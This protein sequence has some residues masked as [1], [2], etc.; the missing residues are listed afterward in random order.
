ME[1]ENNTNDSLLSLI[2]NII[3]PSAILIGSKKFIMI[4]PIYSLALALSFPFCYTIYELIT[5]KKWSFIPILGFC[6]ILLTGSIAILKLPPKLIAV[7]ESLI[8]FIIGLTVLY[9]SRT[10]K[11][12]MLLITKSIFDYEK[13]KNKVTEKNKLADFN[14]CV[15]N[16]TVLLSLSFL[17]STILNFLLA[18]IIVKS[19]AGSIEFNK[20]IGV[21]TALSYPVIAIPSVL[22]MGVSIWYFVNQ[23]KRLTTLSFEEI[24]HEKL[25]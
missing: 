18:I 22:M 3:I 19:P 2:I 10:K 4:D 7:K 25:K 13:I 11:P 8:P 6:S 12:G 15:K 14:R 9:S 24:I 16:A 1:L 20:E 5:T 21:M 17:V 23:V